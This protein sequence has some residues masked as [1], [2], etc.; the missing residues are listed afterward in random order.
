MVHKITLL[1]AL[2]AMMSA[3]FTVKA[4]TC[5]TSSDVNIFYDTVV[6]YHD[7]TGAVAYTVTNSKDI[8]C[9]KTAKIS[10]KRGLESA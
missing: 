3:A 7:Q 6:T 1:F 4:Q 9:N 5:T 8:F 2:L 10:D